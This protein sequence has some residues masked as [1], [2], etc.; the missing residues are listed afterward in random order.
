MKHKYTDRSTVRNNYKWDMKPKPDFW[1]SYERKIQRELKKKI[2]ILSDKI[3]D[4]IWWLSLSEND[5]KSVYDDFEMNLKWRRSY[6]K[7]ANDDRYSQWENDLLEKLMKKYKSILEVKRD[8]VIN[9]IIK[10]SF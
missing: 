8:L 6:I 1:E 4:K 2:K 10:E 7:S 5:Q 3:S 9:E